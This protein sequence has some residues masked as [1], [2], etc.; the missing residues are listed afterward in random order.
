MWL[1]DFDSY[2]SADAWANTV[3]SSME[4]SEK[5][6]EWVKRASAKAQKVRKDEKKAKKYDMILSS[7]LV[8]IILDKRYDELVVLLTS[9]LDKWYPSNF[10]LW[11]FSLVYMDISKTIRHSSN[12]RIYEFNYRSNEF[13]EFSEEIVNQD[14]RKRINI[15]VEDMIDVVLQEWSVIT[16]K[17]LLELFETEKQV[18]DNYFIG[19]FR[20]F[21]KAINITISEQKA[22]NY[23]DFISWELIKSYRKYNFENSLDEDDNF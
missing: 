1:D 17:K 2:E 4:V 5:F 6:K 23:I 13:I 18:L 8:K 12:K 20:F 9:C 16:T 22:F 11:V 21:F 14:I 10:L 3:S 15:W 7:F 19:I